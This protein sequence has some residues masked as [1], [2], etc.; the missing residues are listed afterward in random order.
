[1]IAKFS[2][3]VTEFKI[4]TDNII[5]ISHSRLL[6]RNSE[7]WQKLLKIEPYIEEMLDF[8]IRSYLQDY[9]FV[10]PFS[11]ILII[12]EE[13]TVFIMKFV[14]Q[15]LLNIEDRSKR[16]F[17]AMS[18]IA[19]QRYSF[20]VT[21][22]E[23]MNE[24]IKDKILLRL[25]CSK[26]YAPST[27]RFIYNDEYLGFIS[28]VVSSAFPLLFYTLASKTLL[29]LVNSEEQGAWCDLTMVFIE[30]WLLNN[31]RLIFDRIKKHFVGRIDQID[32]DWSV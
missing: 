8:Y 5:D 6:T 12:N 19:G 25:A 13:L 9:D 23:K 30:I 17:D 26:T 29:D 14:N 7:K 20:D 27:T 1:M 24:R 31:W 4:P 3:M 2:D 11:S 22:F 28:H 32:S 15:Q 16:V 10:T 18:A 21:K